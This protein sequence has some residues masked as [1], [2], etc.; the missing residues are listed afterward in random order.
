MIYVTSESVPIEA[1]FQR[2]VTEMEVDGSGS[3]WERKNR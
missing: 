2:G 1:R 3:T